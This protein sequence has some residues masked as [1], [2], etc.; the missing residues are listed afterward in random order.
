MRYFVDIFKILKDVEFA[1]KYGLLLL[2]LIIPIVAW[3]IWKRRKMEPSL[4]L[5]TA[6]ALVKAPRSWRQKLQWL[7]LSLLMLAFALFVVA[8]ARPQSGFR[9]QQ[10]DVEGVDIVLALDVSGSMK[11]MDFRP[12]R[13]ESCKKVAEE[14]IKKRPTDRIGLV[15]YAGEAYTQCPITTDHETLLG[16][17]EKVKF[18]QV[19]DG[20]AIGDGLG[21]AINRLRE[22]E[23]KSKIIILLTDGVNNTGSLDPHS[24]ADMAETFGIKVYTIGCGSNGE[25]PFPSPYGTVSMKSEIDESLLKLIANTTG[26]KY[27]RATNGD[28]LQQVY[29]EID[30]MEKT[31]IHETVFEHKADEFLPFV[32]IG[33]FFFLLFILFNEV[34]L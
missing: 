17:V 26:G 22:S 11:A 3:Q 8:F 6:E 32:V 1:N 9:Q 15:V 20:T 19:D 23:A 27:F 4:Q 25:V 16:L 10:V 34:I 30:K 5:P 2:L 13:L 12:N 21:T 31:L 7:P 18:N 14:F 28:K 29:A 24:V 33:L